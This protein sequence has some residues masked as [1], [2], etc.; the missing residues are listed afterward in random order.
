MKSKKI[1]ETERLNLRELTLNDV[2]SIAG[3]PTMRKD[4]D[5]ARVPLTGRDDLS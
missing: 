3:G 4:L 5:H 2:E 1:L